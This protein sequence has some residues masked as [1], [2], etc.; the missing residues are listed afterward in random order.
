MRVIK[1]F[2]ISIISILILIASFI[3]VGR[4]FFLVLANSSLK[5]AYK[6]IAKGYASNCY[7]EF[8][9]N[10]EYWTQIRFTSDKNYNL[11]VVCENF[12]QQPVLIEAKKLPAF[13][14]KTSKT[15]GLVLKS[16]NYPTYV[17][18]SSFGRT[19][20][21]YIE[22]SNYAS[23]YFNKPE[24][25]YSIGPASECAAVNNQCCLIEAQSGQGERFN[26]ATDCPKSC[27]ESC[28]QRPVLLSFNSSPAMDENRNVKVRSGAEIEFSYVISET[29]ADVFVGRLDA[30]EASQSS[31][32]TKFQDLF[33]NN[34]NV[35]TSQAASPITTTIDYGDGSFEEFDSLQQSSVHM[36]TC[37]SSLC[38]YEAQIS[39][40]DANEISSAETDLAKILVRVSSL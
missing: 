27:Y 22:D 38:F 19:I 13:V 7:Q 24:L 12:D 20:T 26:L 10:Q 35:N 2:I 3:F 1:V 30:E 25:D 9:E 40:V 29:N 5:S 28:L 37:N 33:D 31:L 15:S 36:Y 32:A 16:D 39:S 23:T 8:G 4:E 6:T 18:L 17:D 14:S 34:Q 21:V 11:E